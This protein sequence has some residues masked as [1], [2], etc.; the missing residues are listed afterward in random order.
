MRGAVLLCVLGVLAGGQCNVPRGA[1]RRPNATSLAVASLN[2]AW[3]FDGMGDHPGSPWADET[4]AAHHL[5]QV[6]R[7]LARLDA[8]IVALQ[9]V[10]RL[11]LPSRPTRLFLLLIL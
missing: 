4:E 9:E 7:M 11:S 10:D 6:A 8:D 3:L 2:A 5:Q 1:D